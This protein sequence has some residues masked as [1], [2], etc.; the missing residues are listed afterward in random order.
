M[1]QALQKLFWVSR[2]IS[3]PNT[4][5]P[6]GAAYLVT[7]GSL[8]ALFWVGVVFFLFPYN[9]LMYGVN[10]VFDYES[11]IK[12]PRKGGIEGMKEQRAFHPVILRASV[13][14]SVPFV[15][16]L[17]WQGNPLSNIVFTALLFFVVAYSAPYL[18]FKE[19]PV[20]DSITSSLH[21]VGPMIYALSLTHY[22]ATAWWYV[23]A[24][25]LWGMASHA[26]GAVQDI[27]PD[28]AGNIASIATVFGARRTVRFAMVLYTAA[29]LMVSVQGLPAFVVGLAGLLY[30]WNI[31][32]YHGVTDARSAQT[33][34]AWRRFIWLNLGTG[35]V[36]TMV[37]IY[38]HLQTSMT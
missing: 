5:Y 10:D 9:L 7:G 20:L 16:W 8:D 2:P 33:N 28:R 4:A 38:L 18:R 24:F 37:L 3:W 29:A 17:L 35:F 23:A 30:V 14:V 11:D 25:F 31:A 21:F 22:S 27:V 34:Q 15:L 36:T 19:R 32:A 13:M 26:F 6:F 1:W 12:N